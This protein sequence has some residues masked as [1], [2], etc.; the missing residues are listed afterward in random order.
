[1]ATGLFLRSMDPESP[2][3]L[4][5]RQIPL[6]G[7]GILGKTQYADLDQFELPSVLVYRTIVI[8]TSPVASRPPQ[9]YRL[10]YAGR[11]YQVWQRS[12]ALARPV[13]A[14]MPPRNS[15]DPTP[16]PDCRALTRLA[17]ATPSHRPPP[18][19]PPR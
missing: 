1:M 12:V 6:L 9:P 19:S 4:R 15:L 5:R 10:V 2:S 11:W 18:P 14:A 3:E 13:L 17:P 16:V 7:G 8:R